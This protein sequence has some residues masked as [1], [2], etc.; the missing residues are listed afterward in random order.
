MKEGEDEIYFNFPDPFYDASQGVIFLGFEKF[1][2]YHFLKEDSP[3]LKEAEPEC[4]D[5]MAL[6]MLFGKE[7]IP[8]V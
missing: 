1:Q 8:D 5:S 7:A 6:V 4:L 2:D 3:I